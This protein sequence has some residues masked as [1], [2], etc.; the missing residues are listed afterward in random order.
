MSKYKI[1]GLLLIAFA[2]ILGAFVWYKNS[3]GSGVPIVFS[4][5][6]TLESLWKNYKEE[7][8]E[9]GTG[10]ALDKQQ[11]NI[12]TSEGQSYAMLRAVWMDDKEAFDLAYK[13]T[14]DNLR[15]KEDRLFSWLFGK[16]QDGTYGVLVDKGGYNTASDANTDIALAL[17][18]AYDRWREDYYLEDAKAIID[19]VWK[20]EVVTIKGKPYLTPDNLEKLSSSK[21]LINPSYFAPYAYR[22]F[23]KIDDTHDWMALVDSSYDVLDSTSELRLGAAASA[24]GTLALPPDWIFM[25]RSTGAITESDIQNL[26]SNYGY[27]ALRVPWKIAVDY[28]W[29]QE[30]RAKEYLDKLTILGQ[31]WASSHMLASVYSHTGEV[32]SASEAPAMYGGS[33][34]YFLV[35]DPNAAKD[36]YEQKLLYLVNPDNGDWKTGLSYYD[37]NWVWFGIALYSGF[38]INLNS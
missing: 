9:Q 24:S 21:V 22:I 34:G 3:P 13:W 29:F 37:A 5:K 11:E 8:I 38:I 15:R 32:I 18:F 6:R 19:D 10:R 35:S 7:Y 33:M 25:N 2:L 23:S 20:N 12:T 14:S 16:K 4:S 27:D 30:P 36:V 1:I 17:I 31:S 26:T 28:Q